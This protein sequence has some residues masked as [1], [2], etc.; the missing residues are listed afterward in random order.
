MVKIRGKVV[1]AYSQIGTWVHVTEHKYTSTVIAEIGIDTEVLDEHNIAW[2]FTDK[3]DCIIH[4]PFAVIENL[5][6]FCNRI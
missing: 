6:D 5:A 2:D 1:K 4:T 3:H